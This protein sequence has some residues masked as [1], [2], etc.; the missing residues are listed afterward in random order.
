MDSSSSGSNREEVHPERCSIHLSAQEIGQ[1]NESSFSPQREQEKPLFLLLPLHPLSCCLASTPVKRPRSPG[2]DGF[3]TTSREKQCLGSEMLPLL[4]F[5]AR[6]TSGAETTIGIVLPPHVLSWLPARAT[7]GV[8]ISP[9]DRVFVLCSSPAVFTT[10][11]PR[12]KKSGAFLT[13]A[14]LAAFWLPGYM[15]RNLL[16][17]LNNAVARVLNRAVNTQAL[18]L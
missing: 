15:H 5:A 10:L 18:P 12:G 11:E 4:A 2:V 8:T 16:I 13:L 7:S 1:W 9:V 17:F 14:T 3:S 6:P